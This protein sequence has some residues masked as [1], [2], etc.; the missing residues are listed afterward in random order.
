MNKMGHCIS[1]ERPRKEA[2]DVVVPF[3]DFLVFYAKCK[4]H[5]QIVAV[6]NTNNGEWV[7]C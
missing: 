1:N 4:K 6:D 5:F 3:H 2:G 7:T